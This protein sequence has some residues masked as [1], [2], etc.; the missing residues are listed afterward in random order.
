MYLNVVFIIVLLVIDNCFL[1]LVK[2]IFVLISRIVL[3]IVFFM[4]INNCM[5]VLVFVVNSDI[6]SVSGLLLNIV[7]VIIFLIFCLV[8]YVVDLGII[9]YNN[10]MFCVLIWC[11]CLI[12]FLMLVF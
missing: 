7:D 8:K 4:C 2:L 10:L 6:Y 5:F 1:K 9:L 12:V 3:G 11:W